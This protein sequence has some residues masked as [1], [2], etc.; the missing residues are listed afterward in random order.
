MPP[1]AS[2]LAMRGG[3]M[4]QIRRGRDCAAAEND[5]VGL[6]R[7]AILEAGFATGVGFFVWGR[8]AQAAGDDA[9]AAA[10]TASTTINAWVR[11]GADNSVTFIC[12]QS[13]MGQGIS[14]TLAAA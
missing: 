2:A 13:E 9:A 4:R 3:T 1:R 12:S 6:T 10:P 14:T 11:I 7:R 8:V 5:A